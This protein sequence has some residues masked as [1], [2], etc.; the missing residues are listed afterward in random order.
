[1]HAGFP[2]L[3]KSW[4]LNFSRRDLR[5]LQPAP[6]KRDIA[7]IAAIWTGCRERFGA[8]GPFLFGAFSIADAM[9]APVVS[10]FKTYG[11]VVLPP[12]AQE[13][14]EM[15]FALPAMREWGD[16]AAREAAE[17]R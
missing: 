7:R 16:A 15:M 6:V 8:G 9:Y 14:A 2:E 1:M 3:R 12:A 5:H 13:W 11:P 10:R 17:A 4:P